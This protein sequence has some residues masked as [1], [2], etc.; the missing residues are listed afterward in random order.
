MST[1]LIILITI[2]SC[3][4]CSLITS[5][6]TYKLTDNVWQIKYDKHI[7]EDDNKRLEYLTKIRKIESDLADEKKKVIENAKILQDKYDSDLR[8]SNALSDQLREQIERL[9]AGR[10]TEGA[11]VD[12]S[13]AN[14]ATDS[15]VYL[16]LFERAERTA[17]DLAGYAQRLTTAVITC[18]NEYDALYNTYH[19]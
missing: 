11:T 9:S 16:R 14:A 4:V 10:T 5:G 15:L 8:D 2:I 13:R 6:L 7:K 19:F 17:T 3:A 12:R 18:N 1:R